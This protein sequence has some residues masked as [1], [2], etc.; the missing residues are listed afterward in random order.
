MIFLPEYY[1]SH[2]D[3]QGV[4]ICEK[5][6]KFDKALSRFLNLSLSLKTDVTMRV[7][8]TG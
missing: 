5:F 8:Y 7:L 6:G 4:P 2:V 1:V 3:A